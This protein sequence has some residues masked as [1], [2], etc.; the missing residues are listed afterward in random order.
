ALAFLAASVWGA[1]WARRPARAG[2]VVLGLGVGLG[3]GV[4]LSWA[5]VYLA[6]LALAPPGARLRATGMAAAATLAWLAPLVKIVG[7]GRLYAL[8]AAHFTGHAGRWGGTVVTEPGVV[9]LRWLARDVLADGFGVG[10][11]ALGLA[12]GL[13]LVVALAVAV[14]AWQRAAWRGW[15]S[16]VLVV[17]PYLLWIGLGQNLRD[18]PRHALPVVV[19]LAAGIALSV[20][21]S[22]RTLGVV[23]A[24]AVLVAMRASLDAHARRTIPPPGVQL[25]ELARV[26]PAGGPID[27][28]GVSSVRFFETTELSGRAFTAGSLGDVQ[29]RLTHVAALP[30]RVWVTGEVEGLPGSPWPLEKQA[31]LCRPA[32]IDRRAPCLDVYSWR[33]PYLPR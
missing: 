6:V 27:V 28:F 25:V 10:F 20:T 4:R 30:S 2:A 17:A 23:G 15:R 13:A 22:R 7:A 19:A 16:A 5:P 24:L 32:R 29:M 26:Q 14:M 9:R 8:T 33:L 11:D 1:V 31:T 18:Q 12:V 3:L 21:R